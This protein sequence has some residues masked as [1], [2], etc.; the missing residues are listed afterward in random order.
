M[1]MRLNGV[2]FAFLLIALAFTGCGGG[3]SGGGPAATD[4]SADQLLASQLVGTWKLSQA[5]KDG[6]LVP[7]KP[8]TT[9]QVGTITFNSDNTASSVDY[10]ISTSVIVAVGGSAPDTNFYQTRDEAPVTSG[11]SWVVSGGS[12]VSTSTNGQTYTN[13]VEI[14][15][16]ELYQTMSDGEVRVWIRA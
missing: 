8:N 11:G 2:F 4:A 13:R 15:N 3:G 1:K 9:G 6:V 16:G 10:T 12:I 5:T 14:K 7:V